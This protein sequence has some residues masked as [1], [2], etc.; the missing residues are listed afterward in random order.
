MLET[1]LGLTGPAV[2]RYPRGAARNVGPSEVGSGLSAR[3]VRSSTRPRAVCILA[4]GKMLEAAE[5][6]ADL[7]AAEGIEAAVWDVRVIRP[8]DPQM[9]VDAGRHELIVT[10][11]DGIR[12][13]G[14][15]AFISD[16]VADLHETRACPPSSS[17]A[18][19]PLTSPTGRRSRSFRSSASTGR[20]SPR[21]LRR[22]SHDEV[23]STRRSD[24]VDPADHPGTLDYL[25]FVE[26]LDRQSSALASA[27]EGSFSQSV[28][29]C[30][31]WEVA[32]VI[33]HLGGVYSWAASAIEAGGERPGPRPAAPEDRSKLLPWFGEA[34]RSS[35]RLVAEPP[36]QGPGVGLHRFLSSNCGVVGTSPGL[37]DR[38]TPLRRRIR[39]EETGLR[40][41]CGLCRC[42]RRRIPHTAAPTLAGALTRRWSPGNLPRT[43]DR[44]A[45]RMVPRPFTTRLDRP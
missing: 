24:P 14:A 41:G 16:A 11:E 21:P 1:A 37:R 43:C 39:D 23:T 33:G 31:G 40:S 19:L 18:F 34:R 13:G 4:I 29:S 26:T 15:G 28:P 45:G 8:I 3:P 10:V 12:S 27:A 20:A 7:L 17:S 9:V 6:A 42:G 2:I 38:S 36:G 22:R 5:E 44:L 30:P 32:D 35:S 25:S